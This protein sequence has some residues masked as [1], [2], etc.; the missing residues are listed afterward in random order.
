MW[1][2]FAHT[3]NEGGSQLL[4]KLMSVKFILF[5][6]LLLN[7]GPLFLIY[8]AECF[9]S[10]FYLFGSA[11]CGGGQVFLYM[12]GGLMKLSFIFDFIARS[13]DHTK[14]RLA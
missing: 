6:S 1:V 2:L 13:Y 4:G 5:H 7:S 9:F 12:R 11:V 8:T 3:E 14:Q 10:N